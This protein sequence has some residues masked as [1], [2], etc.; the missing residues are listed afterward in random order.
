MES[1]SRSFLSPIFV[2]VVDQEKL[3]IVVLMVS[4]SADQSSTPTF[5]IYSQIT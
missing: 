2:K 1:T 3:D 4:D 5:Y